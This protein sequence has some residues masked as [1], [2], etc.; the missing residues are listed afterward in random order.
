MACNRRID[1][2]VQ[3]ILDSLTNL[4]GRR[5]ILTSRLRDSRLPGCHVLSDR[6]PHR[7]ANHLPVDIGRLVDCQLVMGN[8]DSRNTL[9]PEQPLCQ[10]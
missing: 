2:L 8:H 9:D 3:D 5:E 4:V 7:A 6:R 10:G 1:I